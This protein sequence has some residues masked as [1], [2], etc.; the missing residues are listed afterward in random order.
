MSIVKMGFDG[1][2]RYGIAGE[3]PTEPL[4]KVVDAKVVVEKT[5]A[6]ATT[7]DSAGWKEEIPVF[8]NGSLELTIKRDDADVAFDFFHD[9]LEA[10]EPVALFADDGTGEGWDGDFH[11]TETPESQALEDVNQ[12]TVKCALAGRM[13]RVYPPEEPEE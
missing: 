1:V 4:P 3:T 10:D 12:I 5:L 13:T 6:D 11:V 2:L 9:A 8:K 7:R